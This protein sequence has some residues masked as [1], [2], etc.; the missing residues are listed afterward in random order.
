VRRRHAGRTGGAAEARQ[1][2]RA[3]GKK[4]LISM[5]EGF[6]CGH[7]SATPGAAQHAR[8]DCGLLCGGNT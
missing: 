5:P 6:S 7:D 3:G 4:R 2:G 8:A 1:A